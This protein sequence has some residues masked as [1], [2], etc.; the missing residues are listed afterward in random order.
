MQNI[1]VIDFIKKKNQYR[2]EP[3]V[4]RNKLYILKSCY[5]CDMYKLIDVSQII[6]MK[7]TLF[8]HKAYALFCIFTKN[9]NLIFL[10]LRNSII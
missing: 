3:L 5:L 1:H 2:D 7:F 9:D 6:N 4:I 8:E 10:N